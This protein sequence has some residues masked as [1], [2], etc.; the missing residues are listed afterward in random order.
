MIMLPIPV[1]IIGSNKRLLIPLLYLAAT[2][3]FCY[4]FLIALV[5]VRPTQYHKEETLKAAHT[6]DLQRHFPFNTKSQHSLLDLRRKKTFEKFKREVDTDLFFDAYAEQRINPA[7]HHQVSTFK[8]RKKKLETLSSTVPPNATTTE[9]KNGTRRSDPTK[10]WFGHQDLDEP[11]PTVVRP[12]PNDPQCSRF[13]I[14]FANKGAFKPRALL[15]FPGSGNSWLRYLIECSTGIF[16]GSVFNDTKIYSMGMLGELRSPSD[17]S[18]IVQKTHHD[19]LRFTNFKTK[20]AYVKLTE[21]MFGYRGILLIR[22]PY[23]ALI[24]YWNFVETRDHRGHAMQDKFNLFKWQTFVLTMV[25]KWSSMIM[26]WVEN[27]QSL[28]IVEYEQ[29][30]KNPHTQLIRILQHLDQP[31]D[32]DRLTCLLK[33]DNVEGPFHR[34]GHKNKTQNSFFTNNNPF[35]MAMGESATKEKEKNLLDFQVPEQNSKSWRTDSLLLEQNSSRLL[36]SLDLIVQDNIKQI[37]RFFSDKYI[38][39]FLNYRGPTTTTTT[40]CCSQH[41]T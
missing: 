38:P 34:R 28:L 23:D 36:S 17:G 29:V 32:E 24:S 8:S 20:Q 14:R 3:S 1:P 12:W 10:I 31:V 41:K 13:Q 39:I 2:A 11:G 37:N 22:N 9:Q 30:K 4:L 18:T 15:S 35:Q 16:T 5:K 33:P 40:S 7:D 21:L 27:T 26:S 6:S 19:A 25:P